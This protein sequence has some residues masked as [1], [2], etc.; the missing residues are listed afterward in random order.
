MNQ[1][2]IYAYRYLQEKYK[3]QPHQAA[4]IVGNLIQES[5]MNTGARNAGDRS[6]WIG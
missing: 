5:S 3:L 1:N 4:G 6:G 2:A